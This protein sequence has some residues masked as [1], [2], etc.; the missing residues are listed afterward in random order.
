MV[1]RVSSYFPKGGHSAIQ[2]ELKNNMKTP[3]VNSHRKQ[4]TENH[5]ET[6]AFERSVM[7]YW[8]GGKLVLCAH[9]HPQ[10]RKWYKTFSCLFGSQS[11]AFLENILIVFCKSHGYVIFVSVKH[12]CS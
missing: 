2:T 5:N 12:S 3:K 9:S 11:K 7:N 6:T 1:N 10:F 4:A 8:G